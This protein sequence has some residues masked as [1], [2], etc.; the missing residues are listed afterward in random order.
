M[1]RAA[2]AACGPRTGV[3]RYISPCHCLGLAMHWLLVLH[4][5]PKL[6]EQILQKFSYHQIHGTALAFS[7]NKTTQNSIHTCNQ[8]L[9]P[10]SY[11]MNHRYLVAF[12]TSW[13]VNNVST[14]WKMW[15]F[16]LSVQNAMNERC[17][18]TYVR[19]MVRVY[20]RVMKGRV[21]IKSSQHK[22]VHFK[23]GV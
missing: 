13:P 15:A 3:Y 6:E 8:N 19:V 18:R 9:I 10:F 7:I 21:L 20:V 2:A 23:S 22:M 11:Y 12:L 4:K 16:W 5:L 14:S 17:A 1:P